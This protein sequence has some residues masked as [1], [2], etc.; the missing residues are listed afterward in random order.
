[1]KKNLKKICLIFAAVLGCFLM[2]SCDSETASKFL[3]PESSVAGKI[4]GK[5]IYSN[6]DEQ[7]ND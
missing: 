3:E 5:V 7:N 2:S 1:M 4:S 6:L